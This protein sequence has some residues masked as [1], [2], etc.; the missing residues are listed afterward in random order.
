[1]PPNSSDNK[2]KEEV[3]CVKSSK[4]D[5]KC[6]KCHKDSIVNCGCPVI[7]ITLD[8]PTQPFIISE[9]GHYVV[10]NSIQMEIT[11]ARF[12]N[13]NLTFIFLSSNVYLDLCK[14]VLTGTG[15][16][17]SQQIIPPATVGIQNDTRVDSI[18]GIMAFG[19]INAPLENITI[20]NGKLQYYS[21]GI[22]AQF[23]NDLTIFDMQ[24]QKC[25][26][27]TQL[28]NAGASGQPLVAASGGIFTQNCNR[29]KIEDDTFADNRSID[30][31]FS[32]S[33]VGVNIIFVNELTV[34]NCVSTGV[35]GGSFLTFNSAWLADSE[36]LLWG[37]SCASI[38]FNQFKNTLIDGHNITDMRAGD[39]IFG[40]FGR[41]SDFNSVIRNCNI[42]GITSMYEDTTR[43]GNLNPTHELR[44]IVVE[45]GSRGTLIED[46]TVEQVSSRLL[47]SAGP[48]A[49]TGISPNT[50]LG[51]QIE[52]IEGG[53][54]R[55]C[56][57]NS[58]R[59][60]G[61]ILFTSTPTEFNQIIMP[62]TA[63]GF[64]GERDLF[65]RGQ[66]EGIAQIGMQGVFEDCVAT[67]IDGF[68][69]PLNVTPDPFGASPGYGFILG[70]R[71]FRDAS[72]GPIPGPT[73]KSFAHVFR[74]CTAMDCTGN[75]ESGHF[76]IAPRSQF[77]P[78]STRPIQPTLYE[79]CVAQHDRIFRPGVIS[80]GFIT[81]TG[82]DVVYRNCSAQGVELNGFELQATRNS[83]QQGRFV[84]DNC[85]ANDNL[86]N[87]F[88]VAQTMR[89]IEIINSKSNSNLLNGFLIDGTQVVLKNNEANM[90]GVSVTVGEG[91]RV[92]AF[93]DFIVRVATNAD[94]STLVLYP[95]GYTLQYVPGTTLASLPHAS[96]AQYINFIPN[97][98]DGSLVLPP[99]IINGVSLNE[100]DLVLVKDQTTAVAGQ[101]TPP[102]LGP[103]SLNGVYVVKT[104]AGIVIG[105]VMTRM[106][107]LVRADGWRNSAATIPNFTNSVPIN[108]IILVTNPPAADVMYTLTGTTTTSPGNVI[109]DT[110]VAVFSAAQAPDP[111][112]SQVVIEDNS[113]F[114]N[115]SNGIHVQAEDVVVRKNIVDRN[116]G[117]GI[118]DDSLPLGASANGNLYARN[119]AYRNGP[120]FSHKPGNYDV[121]YLT[122]NTAN[123]VVGTLVAFPQ[124]PDYVPEAN[125]S[126]I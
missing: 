1:M 47:R 39:E 9:P 19:T 32:G 57:V 88:H 2:G 84:L 108:S 114:L 87:G 22:V 6:P 37:N 29:V 7:P 105:G 81:T 96:W 118:L 24:I 38:A 100:G 12:P 79:N 62:Y 120:P 90:N 36:F 55:N 97:L 18:Y 25:G 101:V 72:V 53:V 65:T 40:I 104:N 77:I 59:T 112:P 119:R 27:L 17:T 117:K 71:N 63:A 74:R 126:I 52:V 46:C 51:I 113:V 125:T 50:A 121:D 123:L 61:N 8:N 44:G 69:T 83:V 67:N 99:L 98:P 56:R 5:F 122:V 91:I 92:N 66:L 124:F 26:F 109:V 23:V 31:T 86:L 28:S 35:R 10:Q 70:N 76:A 4:G 20:T 16:L 64:Y 103:A 54:V 89:K 49:L 94:L 111:K 58:V 75:N 3:A 85:I 116:G 11:G 15:N 80:H 48:G 14:H 68:S 33:G 102:S 78:P 82:H 45:T 73:P 21:A 34:R 41:S 43:F 93:Y 110:N 60:R 13:Q 30:A 42:I 95:G 106:Y 115:T 107:Q